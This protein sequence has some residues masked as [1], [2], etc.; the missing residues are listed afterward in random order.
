[1]PA[2]AASQLAAAL[3]R[4][5][6]VAQ[7]LLRDIENGRYQIGERLP[8]E[9]QV[10]AQFGVSRHTAREAMRRLAEAG[11][12]V[13]RAGVGT[14]VKAANQAQGRYTARVSDLSDLFA[15]NRQ[16]RFEL[17]AEDS[18]L[19]DAT[20]AE[21]LPGASGQRWVRFT[22]LRHA[23]RT[24]GP[25]VHTHILMRPGY[26]AVRER[27]GEPG[28]MV[29]ELIEHLHGQRISELRQEISCVRTPAAIARLLGTRPGSPALRVLRWYVAADASVLSVAIN[30]Y[31]EERFKLT[32]RWRLD[33][34]EG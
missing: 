22:V 27:I 33:R 10:C 34:D 25:I 30:T 24:P 14:T 9:A 17:L 19:V 16:T 7:A 4:Y 15:F 13:R 20:L 3:P 1:M 32:T 6:V 31:P 21:I 26:E 18:V 12:L 5:R 28:A 8:T 23:P 29:Y 11:M 2:R